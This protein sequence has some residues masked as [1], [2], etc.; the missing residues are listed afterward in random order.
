MKLGTFGFVL[1]LSLVSCQE[2]RLFAPVYPDRVWVATEP[3]QCLGNPWEQ[4][5][6]TSHD[7]R[8]PKD[9]SKPG[10]EP[11]EI[12]II[13]DYYKRQG[14]TVFRV[15]TRAK[16]EVVCAACMCPE[17]YSLYLE[18]RDQDLE[19]MLSFGYREES[20]KGPR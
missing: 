13:Q 11:E 8:Y 18:V 7:G 10:L 9:H 12:E 6:L 4:A 3:I 15:T 2:S 20:P 14:V 1:V 17:G 5:W 16:Y 19:K